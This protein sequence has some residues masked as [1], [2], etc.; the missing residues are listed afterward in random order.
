MNQLQWQVELKQEEV[1][2]KEADKATTAMLAKLEVGIRQLKRGPQSERANL[3]VAKPSGSDSARARQTAFRLDRT[4][5][6]SRAET[7]R[8]AICNGQGKLNVQRCNR[9]RSLFPRHSPP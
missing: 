4:E 1:K 6:R 9:D 2:L 3:R 8:R 7:G 5:D